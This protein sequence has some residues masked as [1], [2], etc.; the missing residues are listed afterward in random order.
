MFSYVNFQNRHCF[1]IVKEYIKEVW[2]CMWCE[3]QL[4]KWASFT[5]MKFTQSHLLKISPFTHC[6]ETSPS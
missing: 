1:Y 6:Q 3:V 5:D 2:F 4:K